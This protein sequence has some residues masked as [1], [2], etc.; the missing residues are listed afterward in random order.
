MNGLAETQ[1]SCP[2]GQVTP[3]RAHVADRSAMLSFADEVRRQH[4]PASMVFNNAGVADIR[5]LGAADELGFRA[6]RALNRSG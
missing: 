2:P 6:R 4:G 3:Y 5:P 1:A